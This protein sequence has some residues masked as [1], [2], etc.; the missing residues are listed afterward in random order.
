MKRLP[1][2]Q[3]RGP[4]Y[5]HRRGGRW[6]LGLIAFGATTLAGAP[7]PGCGAIKAQA[8]H[9]HHACPG[10]MQVPEAEPEAVEQAGAEAGHGPQAEPCVIPEATEAHPG[11]PVGHEGRI[12]GDMAIPDPVAPPVIPVEAVLGDMPVLHP[13]DPHEVPI[14]DPV[15]GDIVAPEIDGDLVVPAPELLPEPPNHRIAGGMTPP[16][17]PP[18]QPELAP[19]PTA[20]PADAIPELQEDPQPDED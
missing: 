11:I 20:P 3:P 13:E 4:A 2:S 5:P 9:G 15:S 18:Q 16:D 7:L 17:F 6:A 8:S 10:D 19:D 14:D 12:R 1:V